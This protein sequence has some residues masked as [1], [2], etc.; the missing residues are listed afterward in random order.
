M[1][2]LIT[3]GSGFTGR[4]LI[5]AIHRRFKGDEILVLDLEPPSF[6][7]FSR[8]RFQAIDLLDEKRI[9]NIII[10]EKPDR[11]IHL[12]GLM[13]AENPLFMVKINV[14]TCG[15]LLEAVVENEIPIDGFL[16]IGSSSQYG[17]ADPR[18]PP[19]EKDACIPLSFYGYSKLLQEQLGM[20]Y[21]QRYNLPVIF[22]RPANL[23]GP[24]MSSSFVVPRI[25]TQL[26]EM[27][28]IPLSAKKQIHLF[29]TKAGRDFIDVRDAVEAYIQLFDFPKT[30]GEIFNIGTNRVILLEEV[31]DQ[32]KKRL[33]IKDLEITE[34]TPRTG[35]DLH[36]TDSQKIRSFIRWQPIIAIE[37]TLN[38]MIESYIR[39]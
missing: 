22:V 17:Q 8:C 15:I 12:A 28:N 20:Q 36:L 24:K 5:P 33:G 6:R 4:F 25:L 38:D 13:R 11:I 18:A 14:I 2:W 7:F 23:L 10:E 31:I 1:K 37:T 26:I 9:T 21:Y 19:T 16:I 27:I 32:A 39:I 30:R 34:E 35:F 29:H 3:G